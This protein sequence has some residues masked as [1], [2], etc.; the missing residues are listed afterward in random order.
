MASSPAVP[1]LDLDTLAEQLSQQLLIERDMLLAWVDVRERMLNIRPRT[2]E[3]RK[4]YREN[5]G[6][7][8]EQNG[9]GHA[10]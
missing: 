7:V 6:R 9:G 5:G 4:W 2:A 3:V 1:A 8:S 10:P